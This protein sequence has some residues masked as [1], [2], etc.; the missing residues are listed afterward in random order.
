MVVQSGS[1]KKNMQIFSTIYVLI[2]FSL[3]VVAEQCFKIIFSILIAALWAQCRWSVAFNNNIH[4]EIVCL[5]EIHPHP[6]KKVSRF[7]GFVPLLHVAAE[8]KLTGMLF[9][10]LIVLTV[11]STAN[12]IAMQSQFMIGCN[13]FF[14]F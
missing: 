6:T 1:T 2:C 9:S 4:A 8:K 13:I 11:P 14:N 12:R 3:T 10:S 7:K 5:Q